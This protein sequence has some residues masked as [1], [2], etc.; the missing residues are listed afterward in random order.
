[1]GDVNV[2]ARPIWRTRLAVVIVAWMVM[3]VTATLAAPRLMEV[4]PEGMA[5]VLIAAIFVVPPPTLLVWSFWAMLREPVTGWLA[6]TVLMA[7]VGGFVPL[8]P[9][10]FD[11]GVRL[12]FESRRPAYE[13]IVA[14]V[15][16]GRLGGVANRRGWVGGAR[17]E[18]RFRYRAADPGVIDFVWTSS[19]GFRVGVRH[20]DTPCVARPGLTCI[21][22]GVP[23][24]DRYTYYARFF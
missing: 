1:M 16:A 24:D 6:P 13:A 19:Y 23:L 5:P 22:R 3:V 2:I 20:D 18:I 9:P 21:A 10:L 11:A 12:N 8:F 17:D 15:R 4:T 14:D 7:F